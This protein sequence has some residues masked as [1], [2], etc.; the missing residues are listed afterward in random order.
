[1]RDKATIKLWP[2]FIEVV[3][4]IGAQLALL[5]GKNLPFIGS[6]H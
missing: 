1:M 3:D 5:L 4:A 2:A 6:G